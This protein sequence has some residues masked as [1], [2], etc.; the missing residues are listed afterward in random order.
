ME[1]DEKIIAF[2][3]VF[4]MCDYEMLFKQNNII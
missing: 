2:L 3:S 4:Y 1:I